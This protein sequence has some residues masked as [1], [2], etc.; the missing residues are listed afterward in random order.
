M[1]NKAFFIFLGAIV[2]VSGLIT[3]VSV[4]LTGISA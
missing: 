3:Q 2:I 4:V 1:T